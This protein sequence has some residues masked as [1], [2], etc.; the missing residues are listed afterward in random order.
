MLPKS[1]SRPMNVNIIAW[2]D[3]RPE[4]LFELRNKTD[5]FEP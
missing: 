1:F 5:G 4:S 2:P 3:T